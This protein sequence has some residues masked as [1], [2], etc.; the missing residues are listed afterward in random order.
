MTDHDLED[1]E[2]KFREQ[3]LV[4]H[5]SDD[6]NEEEEGT[7]KKSK[8]SIDENTNQSEGNKEENTE[9]LEGTTNDV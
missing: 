6:T 9:E 5:E 7:A 8:A 3:E 1:L 2:R 4:E